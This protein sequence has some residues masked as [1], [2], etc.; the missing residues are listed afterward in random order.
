[1]FTCAE[2]CINRTVDYDFDFSYCF[3]M[4]LYSGKGSEFFKVDPHSGEVCINRTIDYDF[5]F[6]YCFTMLLYSG[7]GSEFFKVDPHSG[8]V[9]INRTIDYDEP[10]PFREGT[11]ILEAIDSAGLQNNITI[12]VSITSINDNPPV[13][14]QNVYEVK[15]QENSTHGE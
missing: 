3:T 12:N 4:L 1:M 5:D 11:L 14:E 7:E 13:F 8:E 2:V 9:S 10:S 6:S 15:V